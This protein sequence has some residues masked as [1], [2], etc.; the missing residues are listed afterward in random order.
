VDVSQLL[1]RVTRKIT[2]YL[3]I[4]I[5]ATNEEINTT[6]SKN[7]TNFSDMFNYVSPFVEEDVFMKNQWHS[8]GVSDNK[9][10]NGNE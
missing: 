2:F 10:K 4:I 5:R 3:Q 1:I 6:D 8:Y 7:S 9:F